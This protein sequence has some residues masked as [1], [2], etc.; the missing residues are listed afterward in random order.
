MSNINCSACDE[1][2]SEAPTFVANGVNSTVCASL[3]NDTGLSSSNGHNNA[4]DLEDV[5][6]CLIGRM[7]DEIEAY[8][9]CDWK[10][11]MHKFV[12]NLYETLKAILCSM[13]GLWTNIH[14]LWAKVNPIC[15]TI[16][17]ILKL[18]QGSKP[19]NHFGTWTQYWEDHVTF[20]D[21]SAYGFQWE[22]QYYKPTFRCQIDS[23]AG[24]DSS[25]KIGRYLLDWTYTDGSHSPYVIGM[26]FTSALSV[27]EV[28]A[29]IPSSAV[30]GDDMTLD[31]WKSIIRASSLWQWGTIHQDTVL[32]IA[33]RGYTIIDGVALKSDLA[34]YG[35]DTMV[36][37]VGALIGP[38]TTGGIQRSWRVLRRRS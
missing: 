3:K 35:E 7:D 5:N 22:W 25:K 20:T 24:C 10:D 31:R 32:Y 29:T 33:A 11:Y 12:P 37:T 36:V 38:S 1:L 15:Q 21:M 4:T 26:S 23:G 8:D 18:V 30:V 13:A 27:G 28:I 34:S 16:D 6:D 14:D 2:R 9:V 17:N 19:K